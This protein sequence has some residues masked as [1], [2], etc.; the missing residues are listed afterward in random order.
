M[1][2]SAKT[3][4]APSMFVLFTVHRDGDELFESEEKEDEGSRTLTST[5]TSTAYSLIETAHPVFGRVKRL[6]NSPLESHREV[7]RQRDVCLR[8]GGRR[9]RRGREE[10]REKIIRQRKS[11]LEILISGGVISPPL[12]STIFFCQ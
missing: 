2:S 5:A 9:G 11:G 8:R 6:W 10:Q 4:A 1:S 7:Y 3:N 12:C